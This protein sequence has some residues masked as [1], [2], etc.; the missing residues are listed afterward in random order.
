MWISSLSSISTTCL[1]DRKKYSACRVWYYPQLHA[2]TGGLGR[3]SFKIRWDYCTWFLFLIEA[4]V[5]TVVIKKHNLVLRCG[6]KTPSVVGSRGRS[7]RAG[8]VRRASWRR[9]VSGWTW[10]GRRFPWEAEEPWARRT[11]DARSLDW[12]I[13]PGVLVSGT[14]LVV[15]SHFLWM[16]MKM[17]FL[18]LPKSVNY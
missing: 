8:L 2:S 6:E 14:C 16:K 17:Y 9:Q 13:H 7:V 4:N 11:E 5:K 10:G 15:S 18:S 3:Y 12:G 1:L